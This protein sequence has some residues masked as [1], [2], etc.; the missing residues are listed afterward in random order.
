MPEP[1]LLPFFVYTINNKELIDRKSLLIDESYTEYMKS[2]LDNQFDDISGVNID[3]IVEMRQKCQLPKDICKI[4]NEKYKL[5]PERAYLIVTNKLDKIIMEILNKNEDLDKLVPENVTIYY[6]ILMLDYLSILKLDDRLVT[7]F[8][9][10]KLIEL[11]NLLKNKTINHRLK[12]ILLK[13]AIK[14]EN[15]N[16][17]L[18][19]ICKENDLNIINDKE[20]ILCHI[21]KILDS[22]N[23]YKAIRD[24]HLKEKHR[25]RAFSSLKNKIHRELNDRADGII[26]SQLLIEGLNKRK[27]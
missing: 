4:L 7:I 27:P 2:I 9:V 13:L 23:S 24:Y 10:D 12:G 22:K 8:T 26:L 15:E 19:E 17:T 21:N 11:V 14:K 25:D 1:N 3:L 5:T 6:S 20:L 16:K 18:N